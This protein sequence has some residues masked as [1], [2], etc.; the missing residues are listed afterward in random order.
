[1]QNLSVSDK[2]EKLKEIGLA[3]LS[4]GDIKSLLS[5]C[6]YDLQSTI[7]HYFDNIDIFRKVVS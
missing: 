6:H 7:M 5:K 2:I 1:M 4:D 3:H